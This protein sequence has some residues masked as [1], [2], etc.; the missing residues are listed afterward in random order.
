MKQGIV[1]WQYLHSFHKRKCC[2]KGKEARNHLSFVFRGQISLSRTLAVQ[3]HFPG[4]FTLMGTFIGNF[5]DNNKV[6]INGKFA[7]GTRTS[8]ETGFQFYRAIMNPL[9]AG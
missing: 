2:V 3:Y 9:I 4:C 7:C 1:G 5:L 6:P 8:A